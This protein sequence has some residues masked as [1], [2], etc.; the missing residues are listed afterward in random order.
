M[1]ARS[2]PPPSPPPRWHTLPLTVQCISAVHQRYCDALPWAGE[3]CPGRGPGANEL[4]S[5]GH[6]QHPSFVPLLLSLPDKRACIARD[7]IHKQVA[8]LTSRIRHLEWMRIFTDPRQGA[9]ID[10]ELEEERALVARLQ[11]E[12]E[13]RMQQAPPPLDAPVSSG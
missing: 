6:H 9:L 2:V 3:M 12:A 7:E 11:A 5:H 1:D 8:L 10:V 13:A 4:R